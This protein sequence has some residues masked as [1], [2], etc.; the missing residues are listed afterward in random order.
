MI[1]QFISTNKNYKRLFNAPL[2]PTLSWDNK[3]DLLEYLNDPTCYVNQIVGCLGKAYIIIENDGVKDLKEI[4]TVVA[5]GSVQCEL[6]KLIAVGETEPL[7]DE[8]I[9]I[10]NSY[11]DNSITTNIEDAV[12]EEFRGM[13]KFLTNKIEEL[14]Q[15]NID[16]EARVMYLEENGGGGGTVKPDNPSG[17]DTIMT[18]EGDEIM[19]FE[20]NK[21]LIF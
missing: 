19:I 5:D 21:I 16:L 8:I 12:I 6:E 14:Q 1:T 4:G 13:F 3:N 9:W 2:D 18:F 15:K 10:D 20:D 7:E 11:I 17:N